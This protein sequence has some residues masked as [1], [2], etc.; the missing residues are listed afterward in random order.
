MSDYLDLDIIYVELVWIDLNKYI[1]E[2][3]V[4]VKAFEE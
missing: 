2:P 3:R 4:L 1:L